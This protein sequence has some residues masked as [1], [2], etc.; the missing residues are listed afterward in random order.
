MFTVKNI[1]KLP[2]MKCPICGDP[3][4]IRVGAPC[5]CDKHL[6]EQRTLVL[7]WHKEFKEFVK[8]H[9]KA[10]LYGGYMYREFRFMEASIREIYKNPDFGWWDEL[11][12]PLRETLERLN[13]SPSPK[14][15]RSENHG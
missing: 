6:E 7:A 2:K 14:S 10:G 8:K 13:S 9:I 11:G 4:E 3:S 5:L 12:H 15:I 1:E